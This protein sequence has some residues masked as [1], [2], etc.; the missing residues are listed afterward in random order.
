MLESLKEKTIGGEVRVWGVKGDLVGLKIRPFCRTLC[1]KPSS[2]IVRGWFLFFAP[3]LVMAERSTISL[4]RRQ[5]GD[6][7][8]GAGYLG[9]ARVEALLVGA[10][11]R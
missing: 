2:L 7:S 3:S 11:N 9:L 10:E 6:W 1:S 4:V 5:A 8:A